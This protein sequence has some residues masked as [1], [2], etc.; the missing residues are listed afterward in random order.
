LQS[1][2]DTDF[3]GT[4]RKLQ[5]VGGTGFIETEAKGG[6]HEVGRPSKLFRTI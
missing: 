1:V 3:I 4:E 6:T 2:H 5:P